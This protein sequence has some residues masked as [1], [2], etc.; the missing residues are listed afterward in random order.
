[1][2][3]NPYRWVLGPQIFTQCSHMSPLQGVLRPFSDICHSIYVIQVAPDSVRDPSRRL[4]DF[5]F[6]LKTALFHLKY[7]GNWVHMKGFFILFHMRYSNLL[8]DK[9]WL[10]CNLK[11][12]RLFAEAG[13]TQEHNS[14]ETTVHLRARSRLPSTLSGIFP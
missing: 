8:S 1:M 7:Q 10:G 6:G 11:C 9:K 4:N 5:I 3:H 14:G 12:L 2:L 13:H